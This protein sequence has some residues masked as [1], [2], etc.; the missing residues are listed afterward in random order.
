[1]FN[2][3]E[4]L[5]L[6]LRILPTKATFLTFLN[7]SA[8]LALKGKYAIFHSLGWL[9]TLSQSGLLGEGRGGCWMQ[10]VGG[11]GEGRVRRC[12]ESLILSW[13]IVLRGLDR[14]SF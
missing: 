4:I 6:Y 14:N 3:Q 13:L 10:G 5:W 1:M 2:L 7:L 11:P 9:K 8:R 12:A